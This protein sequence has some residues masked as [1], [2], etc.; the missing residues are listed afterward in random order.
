MR[1][2]S[3]RAP[4][5]CRARGQ[6]LAAQLV[7]PLF[8]HGESPASAAA[9]CLPGRGSP[10]APRAAP[11]ALRGAQ[12][13]R[14]AAHRGGTAPPGS[15]APTR[16]GQRA[17]HGKP[18]A[19]P[20]TPGRAAAA[21]STPAAGPPPAARAGAG[22]RPGRSWRAACGRAAASS[23]GSATCG[24]SPAAATSSA[25]YRHPVHPSIAKSA[26][27]GRR[28]A[29]ARPARAHG[30]PAGP[31]RAAPPR[32]PV[33][34]SKVICDRWISSPP[35]MDIGTSSSSRGGQPTYAPGTFW[36]ASS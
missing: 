2:C 21:P 13:A 4:A 32:S 33:D 11:P 28:T 8:Q 19:A 34:M 36:F 35:T 25:T 31:A 16:Y 15:A 27:L 14:C 22:H 1:S 12:R 26:V 18:A 10:A 23:A 17:G 3:S 6:L 29:P 30:R 9:T 24:R 7:Q 20:G 5:R